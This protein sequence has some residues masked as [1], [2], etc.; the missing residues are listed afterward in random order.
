MNRNYKQFCCKCVACGGSTSKFY[1]K[2]HEG[3]CKSCTVT[4][5]S[6]DSSKDNALLI[7]SGYQAFSRE[8][9][10]YDLPDYS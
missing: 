7:D 10:D 4:G 8:R 5:S 3:L 9:G 1:A 6:K 2:Q